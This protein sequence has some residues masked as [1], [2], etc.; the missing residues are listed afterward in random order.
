V[1]SQIAKN[2]KKGCENWV[3]KNVGSNLAI[4]ANARQ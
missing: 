3:E 1:A 4:P 2:Y